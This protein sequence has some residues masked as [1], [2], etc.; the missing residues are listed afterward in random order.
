MQV[1][2]DAPNSKT[3]LLDISYSQICLDGWVCKSVVE[4][5]PF[6]YQALVP[7]PE[8][9]KQKVS[10]VSLTTT[11]ICN[12]AAAV[13]FKVS[14][15]S[16][17]GCLRRRIGSAFFGLHTA[18]LVLA[19]TEFRPFSMFQEVFSGYT[20]LISFTNIQSLSGLKKQIKP[21]ITS[22]FDCK[23]AIPGNKP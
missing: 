7:H 13:C 15:V 10:H 4:E 6:M 9:E 1:H 3:K 8:Q 17:C 19:L 23:S 5:L 16:P 21:Q 22:F 14:T 11:T 2:R 20:T 12:W 18:F